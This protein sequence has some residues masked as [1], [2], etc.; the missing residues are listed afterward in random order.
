VVLVA[1]GVALLDAG[2]ATDLAG[3]AAILA[4]A[5][6]NRRAAGRLAL[7]PAPS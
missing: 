4:V 2:V 5:L 1:A 6:H 3:A 7:R